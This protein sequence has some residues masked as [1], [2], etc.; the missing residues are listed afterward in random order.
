M[1]GCNVCAF[2]KS[3]SARIRRVL[4]SENQIPK[5]IRRQYANLQPLVPKNALSIRPRDLKEV[6]CLAMAQALY[7]RKRQMHLILPPCLTSGGAI[8]RIAC[9]GAP[10]RFILFVA[11]ARQIS[12]APRNCFRH[13]YSSKGLYGE[14]QIS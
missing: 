11:N 5:P 13:R 9:Q 10:E 2:P 8:H 3:F 4:L 7:Q 12:T 1:G 6:G 14:T